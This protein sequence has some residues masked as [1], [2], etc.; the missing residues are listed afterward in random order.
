MTRALVLEL[1][2]QGGNLHTIAQLLGEDPI[3][4]EDAVRMELRRI[5]DEFQ[6]AE[7]QPPAGKVA[8]PA[9]PALEAGDSSPRPGRNRAAEMKRDPVRRRVAAA[10]EALDLT[11]YPAALQDPRATSQR[12]VLGKLRMRPMTLGEVAKETGLASAN[13]WA[14]LASLRGKNLVR[15]S[16]DTPVVWRLANG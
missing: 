8:L 7:G 12:A 2:M 1:W 15:G 9:P 11:G 16:E 5:R 3:G 6:P 13:V 14:A 4:L 10:S